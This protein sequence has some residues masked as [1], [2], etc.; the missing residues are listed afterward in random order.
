M[1]G[2]ELRVWRDQLALCG[3]GDFRVRTRAISDRDWL[4]CAVC[5]GAVGVPGNAGK[6]GAAVYAGVLSG[7]DCAGLDAVCKAKETGGLSATSL[8]QVRIAVFCI[9][10]LTSP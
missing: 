3:S 5:C 8:V 4:A 6:P 9:Y 2:G 7:G 10:P 1:V